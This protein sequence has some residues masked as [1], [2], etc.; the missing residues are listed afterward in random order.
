MKYSILSLGLMANLVMAAPAPAVAEGVH[1]AEFTKL[2]S[3]TDVS[4]FIL[5]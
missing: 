3:I 2:A 5:P 4:C 1:F